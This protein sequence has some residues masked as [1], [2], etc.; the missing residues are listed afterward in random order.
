MEKQKVVFDVI[1]EKTIETSY[2][3]DV[4]TQFWKNGTWVINLTLFDSKNKCTDLFL[5]KTHIEYN[6]MFVYSDGTETEW[7]SLSDYE[8]D[9]FDE[10]VN[11]YWEKGINDLNFN[12]HP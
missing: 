9:I 6:Y 1:V 3:V 4:V 12:V 8:I 5:E 10:L 7:S 2:L 11:I